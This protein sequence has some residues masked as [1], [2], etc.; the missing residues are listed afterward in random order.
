MTARMRQL[1][2]CCDGTNNTLTAGQNDTNVLKLYAHLQ[3]QERSSEVE[4]VLYDAPGV[5][6]SDRW[7]CW[8]QHGVS[9][10]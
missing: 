3:A 2:V 10:P 7:P 6:S 8:W 1:V 5:G 4:R 9:H